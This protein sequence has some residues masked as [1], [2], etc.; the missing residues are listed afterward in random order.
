MKFTKEGTL[1]VHVMTPDQ[2]QE[3]V[4]TLVF[5]LVS[6]ESKL[7]VVG[8]SAVS[9][10]EVKGVNKKRGRELAMYRAEAYAKRGQSRTSFFNMPETSIA[11]MLDNLEK[12]AISLFADG[13]EPVDED[14]VPRLRYRP[15]TYESFMKEH[16]FDVLEGPKG[17]DV[18]LT[19]GLID[20]GQGML[21]LT[22]RGEDWL[23]RRMVSMEQLLNLYRQNGR[24]LGTPRI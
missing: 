16:I 21:L 3:Q 15:I 8:W 1:T 10:K 24:I 6:P 5:K 17:E 23:D 22:V 14:I 9:A 7:Y 20:D 13:Y 12:I 11:F 18:Q 4:G 19:G 2:L